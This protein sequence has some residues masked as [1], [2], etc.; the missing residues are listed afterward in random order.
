MISL[1]SRVT[2]R[3][4]GKVILTK[5]DY[6]TV[7]RGGWPHYIFVIRGDLLIANKVR[8]DFAKGFISVFSLSI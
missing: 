3:G 7:E 4:Y 2:T 8:I 6:A 1:L 5:T